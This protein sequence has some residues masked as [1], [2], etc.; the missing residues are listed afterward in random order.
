[1]P[2]AT[3]L[4]PGGWGPGCSTTARLGGQGGA[5]VRQRKGSTLALPQPGSWALVAGSIPLGRL[6]VLFT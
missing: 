4:W 2:A 5:E 3:S 1:M 6:N